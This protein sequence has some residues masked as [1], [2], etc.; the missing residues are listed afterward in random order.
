VDPERIG[1]VFEILYQ[2]NL[3]QFVVLVMWIQKG[4]AL[5]KKGKN[6]MYY[7]ELIDVLFLGPTLFLYLG[8][9]SWRPRDKCIKK[10]YMIT[11]VFS[12]LYN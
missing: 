3:L 6:E 7:F 1:I 10:I 5:F 11:M 8:R 4:L 12:P 2:G 9:P